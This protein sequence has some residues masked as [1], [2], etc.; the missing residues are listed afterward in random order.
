MTQSINIY[1]RIDF[2][3]VALG[4]VPGAIIRWQLGNHIVPN[5]VGAAVFGFLASI[6]LKQRPQLLIGAGFCGSLTTFSGW[7]LSC[8]KLI[9]IGDYFSAFKLLFLT[10]IFGLIAVYLGFSLGK[11]LNH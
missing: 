8:I 1:K 4:A 11:K 10:M 7:L 6:S 2:L 3:F 5:L 9:E